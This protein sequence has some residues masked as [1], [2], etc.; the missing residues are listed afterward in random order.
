MKGTSG[1]HAAQP[2]T[3]KVQLGQA[4]KFSMYPV[5]ECPQTLG[6]LLQCPTTFL[7]LCNQSF[8]R[9]NLFMFYPI[10]APFSEE[11]LLVLSVTSQQ[12]AEGSNTIPPKHFF[13]RLN[14]LFLP[15][16]ASSAKL[17]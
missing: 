14:K 2:P 5:T 7:I 13:L 9:S 11:I 12:V 16:S 17:L 1:E 10:P 4:V 3:Q 8:T 15:N 6:N